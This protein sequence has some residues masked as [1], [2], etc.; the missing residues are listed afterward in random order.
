[1]HATAS[2]IGIPKLLASTQTSMLAMHSSKTLP[3]LPQPGRCDC[4]R[5]PR[6]RS[7]YIDSQVLRLSGFQPHEGSSSQQNPET[8]RLQAIIQMGR[9]VR[10][11]HNRMP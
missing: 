4:P 8:C 5:H 9:A 7:P 6:E 3:E 1:M 11:Q 10:V 2:M